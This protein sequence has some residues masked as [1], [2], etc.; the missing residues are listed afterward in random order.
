M[1]KLKELSNRLL[2]EVAGKIA[3]DGFKARVS[4]QEY[5]KRENFGKSYF[6]LSFIRHVDDFHV[7]A[8]VAIRFDAIE[9]LLNRYRLD[10]T[11]KERRESSSMGIDLGNMV[12]G[13][14]KRWEVAAPEDVDRAAADIAEWFRK[15]ALPYY[16][17]YSTLENALEVFASDERPLSLHCVFNDVRAKNAL[18][19]AYL[20]KNRPLFEELFEK[21]KQF[22][23]GRKDE[24]YTGFLKLAND[25]RERW[26]ESN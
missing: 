25:L 11:E 4:W 17:R 19:V 9:N 23:E 10:L 13:A 1:T 15:Y 6:H 5:Y 21:K 26:L 16:E 12:E 2:R 3:G 24:D 14:Q 20:M 22:L 7:T 18:A 8:D